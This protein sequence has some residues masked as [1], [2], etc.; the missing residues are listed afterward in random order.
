[1]N[2]CTRVIPQ[3][4]LEINKREI[5]DKT[6]QLPIP[7]VA[8]NLRPFDKI[9]NDFASLLYT[10]KSQQIIKK[11]N[12]EFS[13]LTDTEN[14][15]LC[16]ILINNQNCYAKHRNDVGKISTPFRIRIKEKCKLQTQR[17]S[18]VPIHYRDRINK[19]LVELG[20]Y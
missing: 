8:G 10:A 14:V 4:L 7:S 17:P 5:N 18:K 13:D 16:N 19:L 15:N 12:F 9:R 6:L 20:K 11:F 2:L 3:S 1:M